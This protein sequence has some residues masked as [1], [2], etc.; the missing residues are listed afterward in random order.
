[1][2]D[3]AIRDEFGNVIPFPSFNWNMDLTGNLSNSSN[4][5]N[6]STNNDVEPMKTNSDVKLR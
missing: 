5:S 6:Q 4:L 3:N 1:M 2:G